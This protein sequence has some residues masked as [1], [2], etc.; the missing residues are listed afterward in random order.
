MCIAA[1]IQPTGVLGNMLF[2]SI[3]ESKTAS[4][5]A[6][7]RSGLYYIPLVFLLP[8]AFGIFGIQSAQLLADVL[9]LLTTGPFLVS[10]FRKLPNEN[11]E[12]LTDRLY[13]GE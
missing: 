13:R 10:F 12:T 1:A 3:G 2:Q 7:L 5:L 4:F 11:R 6:M 8:R 9:T